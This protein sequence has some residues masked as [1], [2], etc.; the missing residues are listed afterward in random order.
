MSKKDQK[1][2]FLHKEFKTSVLKMIK[3]L[4]EDVNNITKPM[5]EQNGNFDKEAENLKIN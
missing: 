5:Y 2:N 4:K 3:D 1:V